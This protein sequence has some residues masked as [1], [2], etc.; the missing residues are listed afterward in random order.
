MSKVA[1][2]VLLDLAK[3]VRVRQLD[4]LWRIETAVDLPPSI[5]LREISRGVVVDIPG[6]LALFPDGSMRIY[7]PFAWD[8]PSPRLK[9]LYRGRML[10]SIGAPLG[11]KIPG[12]RIRV[13]ARGTLRHD[14]LC[15]S[16]DAIA[17]AL[18]RPVEYVQAAADLCLREDIS[19]DW[20]PRWG[21]RFFRA[22][23]SGGDAYR[24]LA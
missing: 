19:E 3:H 15:R 24:A 4:T 7:A 23:I 21:D 17:A 14:R 18:D 10:F 8:G 20:S 6:E 5:H 12:T 2:A 11:P 22:V 9:L 1:T 13:T 16:R